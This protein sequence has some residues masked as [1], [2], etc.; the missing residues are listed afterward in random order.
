ML[1]GA[2]GDTQPLPD[3]EVTPVSSRTSLT[4][5]VVD[6]NQSKCYDDKVEIS[7]PQMGDSFHG[8]DAQYARTEPR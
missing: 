3:V 8:Q 1:L 2:C 4:Y 6:T 7:C 5:V